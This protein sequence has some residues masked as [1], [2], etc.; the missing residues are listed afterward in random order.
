MIAVDGGAAEVPVDGE[1]SETETDNKVV[2][3]FEML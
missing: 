1:V 2:V 3:A